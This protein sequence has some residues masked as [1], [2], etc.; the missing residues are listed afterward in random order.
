[1]RIFFLNYMTMEIQMDD[2]IGCICHLAGNHS[3]IGCFFKYVIFLLKRFVSFAQHL[4][5]NPQDVLLKDNIWWEISTEYDGYY[6]GKMKCMENHIVW[7]F[8]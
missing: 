5:P 6:T 8:V 3:E 2:A 7:H 4:K 1:M